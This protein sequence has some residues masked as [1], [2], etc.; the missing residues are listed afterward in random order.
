MIFPWIQKS[1]VFLA[2]YISPPDERR[3]EYDGTKQAAFADHTI[4]VDLGGQYM[5]EIGVYGL[6]DYNYTIVHNHPLKKH[7]DGEWVGVI[8]IKVRE[9]YVQEVASR[10]EKA[11][12]SPKKN[13]KQKT[14]S[15]KA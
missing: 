12:E 9:P 8:E 14:V 3:V 6:P 10:L 1:V 7:R 13:I 15:V 2:N 5:E 11:L 4:K